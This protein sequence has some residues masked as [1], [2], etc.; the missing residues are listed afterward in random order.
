[1]C[2]CVCA[3][4]RVWTYFVLK[5]LAQS[6]TQDLRKKKKCFRQFYDVAHYCLSPFAQFVKKKIEEKKKR[7]PVSRQTL[8]SS[9]AQ[10][11]YNKIEKNNK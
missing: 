5:L 9:F 10:F 1:V 6:R 11:M 7:L 8:L 4:V 3:C 2:V